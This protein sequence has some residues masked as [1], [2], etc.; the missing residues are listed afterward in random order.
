MQ[1]TFTWMRRADQSILSS[2]LFH[3]IKSENHFPLQCIVSSTA[4]QRLFQKQ[5]SGLYPI[6]HTIREADGVIIGTP[7]YLS[8]PSAGFRTLYERPVFQNITYQK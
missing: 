8:Q 1:L 6:L 4:G 3:Y 2:W 7:N 5:G